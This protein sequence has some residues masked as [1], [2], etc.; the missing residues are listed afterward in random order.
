MR[1]DLVGVALCAEPGAAAYVP[2]GH[3]YI[4]APEQIAVEEV[5][6][7]L[8]PLLE[9]ASL[10]KVGQ[11]VKYDLIVLARHG[12]GMEGIG[13]DTM[14]A[15]YLV[16]PS[17][18]QHNLDAL[19]RDYLGEKTITYEEIAGSGAKQVTLDAVD[20]ETVARYASEDAEVALRLRDVLAPKLAERGLED[21]YESM[22]LPLVP[23]L[24]RMEMAGVK[25]DPGVLKAMSRDL[26]AEMARLEKEIHELAG[27]AFNVNSP[28][29]L[30]DVLFGRLEMKSRRKTAK[31][32][33]MSTSQ[34]V[35]E[36]LAAEHPLPRKV[37]DYRSLAKLKGTYVDALPLLIH[38]GTGRVHTSFN[39]T[40]AA[41]GRLSSTDPNLQ[42][43]PARTE[44][45][46]RI[47]GAFVPEDGWLFLSADYSQVEL[48]VLAHM[49][50]D[51]G[52]QEAFRKGEDIH[53][54]TAAQIFDV[55][56]GLVTE[57]MRRRAKT[58]NFAVLYGMG[59][60]RLA[61]ALSISRK[62]AS[63]FIEQYFARLPRVKE[64][65]DR[66][67]EGLQRDGFVTTLFNRQRPF[68]EIRG[69]DR[70]LIQQALRAAVNTTIQGTAADIIKRAMIAVDAALRERRMRTRVLLQVHDELLLEVPED[71]VDAAGPLV[72]ECMEGACT[73]AA[74]LVVDLK[75]GRSWEEV[76]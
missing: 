49:A 69:T 23:I 27:V 54:R 30:G 72:K 41:T 25:V 73:L 1:A 57:D 43:I 38:P 11:N 29:Q 64:Y 53:R 71:E 32:K 55:M 33:A 75:T 35:L 61:Q 65:V 60:V 9:D 66:T 59:P 52:M 76:T 20:V 28:K 10:P 12:S 47:R 15:S 26:E 56:P 48:R 14:V 70:M 68:P 13:F 63:T 58:I 31:S 67:I 8:R 3:R 16:D 62:E 42:N 21:L 37:L 39:Q 40:V 7:R 4:G 44:V 36:Q 24:A 22:E 17:R 50:D 5:I 46:R 2:V 34:E 74:P 19:A 51:P 18:R 6:A 45:G